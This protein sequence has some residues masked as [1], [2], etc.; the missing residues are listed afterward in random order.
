MMGFRTNHAFGMALGNGVEILVHVGIDTVTLNGE[1]FERLAN[2][3]TMLQVGD[4]VLRIQ[5]GILAERGMSLITPV[6]ITN[7]DKVVELQAVGQGVV[8]AGQDLILKYRL[9]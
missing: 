8:Q 3:G 4:P 7:A 5:R 1:G 2:E 9:K 6:V